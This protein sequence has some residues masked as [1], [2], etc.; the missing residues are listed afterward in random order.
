MGRPGRLDG[1][2]DTWRNFVTATELLE[3]KEEVEEQQA[4]PPRSLSPREVEESG[5][6]EEE[7]QFY[8]LPAP[9]S[10]RSFGEPESFVAR[11]KRLDAERRDRVEALRA[12]RAEAE[13]P[14]VPRLSTQT[15][16]LVRRLEEEG[17]RL[18]SSRGPMHM[19]VDELEST[20]TP[21]INTV[22]KLHKARSLEALST[23]CRVPPRHRP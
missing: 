19:T 3:Q 21:Q 2:L 20:F 18:H 11:Q 5:Q 7:Q 8:L 22:S 9:N 12:C 14:R 23:G 13:G 4:N 10:L 15:Q 1:I 17:P 16:L 6:E